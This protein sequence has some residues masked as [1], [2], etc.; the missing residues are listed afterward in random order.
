MGLPK[1]APGNDSIVTIVDSL[2]SGI[3]RQTGKR[4]RVHRTQEQVLRTYI[5]SDE[6]V[7]EGLLPAVEL[8]YKCTK[9]TSTG[10]SPFEVMI[11]E[12]TLR[13][14]DLGVVDAYQPTLTPPLTML[15]QR[16]VDRAAAN[17][18]HA[19]AQQKFYANQH[20]QPAEFAVGDCVW[21]S[22]RHM[23]PHGRA[24]IR[25]WFI[26]PFTIVFK[27]GK[28]AYNLDL[29]A[30]MQIHTVF[31]S[32][33]SE[34]TSPGPRRCYLRTVGNQQKRLIELEVLYTDS[35]QESRALSDLAFEGPPQGVPPAHRMRG[36]AIF[37]LHRF[38]SWDRA[39]RVPGTCWGWS[40]GAQQRFFFFAAQPESP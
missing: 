33:F 14:N 12:N 13:A 20:R 21:M 37:V 39:I 3:P 22:N 8:A 10:L 29:P 17:I 40:L 15:F 5:Q 28:V 38:L 27:I 36:E 35:G 32:A 30:S 26:A 31:M 24:K 25:P 7:W 34:R 2:R 6:A 23:Q 16:L 4:E 11:G 9:H 1:T 18:V 19:Q